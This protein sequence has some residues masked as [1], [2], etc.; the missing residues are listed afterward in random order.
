MMNY[1]YGKWFPCPG[2]TRAPKEKI[3]ESIVS[4][5]ASKRTCSRID[6][7][8]NCR[9]S[10]LCACSADNADPRAIES[11]STTGKNRDEKDYVATVERIAICGLARS[12]MRGTG[13][14]RST[15]H[16]SQD[17]SATTP[18]LSRC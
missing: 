8:G 6:C 16:A 10:V 1:S 18:D 9:F 3:M 15:S 11:Q 13:V 2:N 7:A 5:R 14:Q 4:A 17:G 12:S